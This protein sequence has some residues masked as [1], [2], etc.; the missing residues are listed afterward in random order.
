VAEDHYLMPT[1]EDFDRAAEKPTRNPTLSALMAAAHA[2]SPD[3]RKAVSPA[4]A[5]DTAVEVPPR[6]VH[7]NFLRD[8][9][10]GHPEA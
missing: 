10:F 6:A 3:K 2:M 8:F 4:I 1:D 9:S 5:N 7:A